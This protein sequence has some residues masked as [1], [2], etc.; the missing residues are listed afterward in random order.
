MLEEFAL[1][2][3]GPGF[4]RSTYLDLLFY[5][6]SL[7]TESGS[8]SFLC[9][10]LEERESFAAVDKDLQRERE[11]LKRRFRAHCDGSHTSRECSIAILVN[12]EKSKMKWSWLA[13]GTCVQSQ[14]THEYILIVQT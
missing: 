14:S 11:I 10:Y 4:G 8:S 13:G 12:N 6:Q 1:R 2:F 7:H 9:L 5:H 3:W